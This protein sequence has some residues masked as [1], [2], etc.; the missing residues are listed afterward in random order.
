M[1][2]DHKCNKSN[3]V[4]LCVHTFPSLLNIC[5]SIALLTCSTRCSHL[6]ISKLKRNMLPF[7]NRSTFVCFPCKYFIMTAVETYVLVQEPRPFI[8]DSAVATITISVNFSTV[9]SYARKLST[10]NCINDLGERLLII[11]L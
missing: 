3:T 10:T 7:M 8:F 1:F 4:M 11:L 6:S 2:R 5:L 9:R